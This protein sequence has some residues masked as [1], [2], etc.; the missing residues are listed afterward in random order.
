MQILLACIQV[1]I[2]GREA[3]AFAAI[4]VF[5]PQVEAVGYIPVQAKVG[6]MARCAGQLGA[7]VVATL[8]FAVGV[9]VV[10]GNIPVVEKVP[11]GG[12]FN[13]M[14]GCF[15]TVDQLRAGTSGITDA[16]R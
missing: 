12:Q 6:Y 9:G 2:L 8:L 7:F 13:P 4:F 5:Q 10:T 3:C 15:A 16:E 11:A 14:G 1:G